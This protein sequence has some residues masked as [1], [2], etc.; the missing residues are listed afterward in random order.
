[1]QEQL[2][3]STYPTLQHRHKKG[4]YHRLVQE[5]KLDGARYKVYFRLNTQQ[6]EDLLSMLGPNIGDSYHPIAFNYKFGHSTVAGI[7][8]SVSRSIWDCLVPQLMLTPGAE[9]WKEIAEDFH[10]LWAFPNCCVAIHGK[11]VIIQALNN[12]GSQFYNYKG[13]FSIVLLAVDDSHW[14]FRVVDVGDFGRS[15]NEE[16]LGKPYPGHTEQ[17]AFHLSHPRETVECAFFILATQWRL[18]R[19]IIGV[20]P[21]VA[22]DVVKATS[23]LHNFLWWKASDDEVN[24]CQA[25]VPA[26]AQPAVQH[27]L[28][29]GSNSASKEALSVRATY[30]QG[31]Y[32]DHGKQELDQ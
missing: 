32:R 21:W 17:R 29:M 12:I 26:E 30:T 8:Q 14:C 23:I 27:L 7:V 3:S 16:T 22:D 1:S 11:H 6:F 13:S 25:N 24:E 28:R 19:R 9:D 20:S 4:E 18:Y 31:I 15:S 10:W 2:I 5:L